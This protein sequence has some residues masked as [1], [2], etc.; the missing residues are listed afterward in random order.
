MELKVSHDTVSINEVIFEGSAEQPV[1]LD[2]N[3]PDYCPDI[4]RILKC[5]LMPAV[6]VRQITGDR[7]QVEGKTQVSIL[8]VDDTNPAGSNAWSSLFPFPRALP[9]KGRL[10]TRPSSA[11][12]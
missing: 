4:S 10:R 3:L 1:D 9:C 2:I 5:R 11:T 7:L 8:Y 6:S 12:P